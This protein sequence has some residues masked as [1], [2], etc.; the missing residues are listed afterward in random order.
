V[1]KTILQITLL[2]SLMMGC[3][4]NS[5]ATPSPTE[6]PMAIERNT[7]KVEATIVVSKLEKN[8]EII[9]KQQQ[10]ISDSSS[11]EIVLKAIETSTKIQGITK[12]TPPD[13]ELTIIKGK[14]QQKI[15]SLWLSDD[16]STGSIMDKADTHT[17]YQVSEAVAKEMKLLLHE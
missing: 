14:N 12:M 11:V 2:F 9:S 4:S 7:E 15:Y 17:I 5:T 6:A 3:Q 8:G 10:V 16:R 13:F 1:Q